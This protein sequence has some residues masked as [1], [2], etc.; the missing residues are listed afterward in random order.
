MQSGKDEC[1]MPFL[2]Q[3]ALEEKSEVLQ[4]LDS[5]ICSSSSEVA[6]RGMASV[7]EYLAALAKGHGGLRSG[8]AANPCWKRAYELLV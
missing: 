4:D 7:A 1:I 3:C 2:R 5:V 6:A 8:P